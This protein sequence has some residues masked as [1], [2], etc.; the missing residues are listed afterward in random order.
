MSSSS[1][2]PGAVSAPE[3][4]E[5]LLNP[6]LRRVDWRFLLPAPRFRRAICFADGALRDGVALVADEVVSRDSRPSGTCDLAVV[7][8]PAA[9]TLRS[10]AAALEPGGV[11]Y[12]ESTRSGP[13]GRR[14]LA[15][16]LR[17]AGLVDARSFLAWHSA[18]RA[19]VWVPL[20]SPEA[21]RYFARRLH[22]RSRRRQAAAALVRTLFTLGVRAGLMGSVSTVARKSGDSAM[23]PYCLGMIRRGRAG[24][25]LPGTPD[26]LSLMLLT[27]GPRTGSKIAGLVFARGGADPALIVKLSRSP[28]AGAGLLREARTLQALEDSCAGRQS[29]VPR[30]VF[31]VEDRSL[32]AVA[33]TALR[34]VPL[35]SLLNRRN[36]RHY[37]LQA[38]E[39]LIGLAHCSRRTDPGRVG[40]LVREALAEFERTYGAVVEPMALART[41]RVL[42]DLTHVPLGCEHRDFSPWNVFVAPDGRLTVFDWESSELAGVPALDL[43]YFLVY[44]GSALQGP[45]TPGG[46]LEAA[47]EA[48]DPATFTGGVYRECTAKYAEMTGLDPESLPALRLLLWM[49]HSRSEHARMVADASGPPPERVLRGSLFLR[50]WQEELRRGRSGTPEGD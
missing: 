6:R 3:L 37:A 47:S 27:G 7:S 2:M 34:G 1:D 13:G 12:V 38:T 20:Q 48:L 31:S 8:E 18:D 21:V 39:W 14:R 40:G 45:I 22:A 11:C 36:Y 32:V 5:A 25:E 28:A 29:G 30:A 16:R 49:L 15:E 42:S 41:R 17:E 26:D 43:L 44:L 50:L 10:A 4:P 46:V 33:E 9:S 35:L 19:S 24:W 23:E